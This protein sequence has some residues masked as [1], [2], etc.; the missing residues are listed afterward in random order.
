M[1]YKQAEYQRLKGDEEGSRSSTAER[2]AEE[3]MFCSDP[4]TQ[5]LIS[6]IC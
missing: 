4:W 1:Y 5:T 3:K 2:K 6:H